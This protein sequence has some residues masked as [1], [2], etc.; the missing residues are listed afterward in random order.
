MDRSGY[1]GRNFWKP[2]P[3]NSHKGW[4]KNLR[5]STLSNLDSQER[6]S[7]VRGAVFIWSV[8]ILGCV[9]AASLVIFAGLWWAAI[10]LVGILLGAS[11]IWNHLT[12]FDRHIKAREKNR[13]RSGLV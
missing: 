4:I 9:S 7:Y 8:L 3:K 12:G 5:L 10:P 6:R 2:T 11:E 1:A 13:K